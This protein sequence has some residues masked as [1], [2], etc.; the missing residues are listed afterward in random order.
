PRDG[1]D[2]DVLLK[3]ADA[4]MYLAKAA[5][6]GTYRFYDK[7]LNRQAMQQHDLLQGLRKAIPEG[8]LVL[9]YQPRLTIRNSSL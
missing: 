2:I 7:E 1:E 6:R 3:H 4:A 9:H 5:G 8:G